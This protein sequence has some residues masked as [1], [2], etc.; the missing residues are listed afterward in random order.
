MNERTRA[1]PPPLDGEEAAIKRGVV[2][3]RVAVRRV[4]GIGRARV[5]HL[6][7]RSEAVARWLIA[8]AAAIRPAS[9]WTAWLAANLTL[10]HLP[11]GSSGQWAHAHIGPPP[12]PPA[13]ARGTCMAIAEGTKPTEP[14]SEKSAVSSSKLPN[15]PS[16]STTKKVHTS[17]AS[18][19]SSAKSTVSP[20]ARRA[21]MVT[22]A[23]ETMHRRSALRGESGSS[24]C[25]PTAAATASASSSAA[26]TAAGSE[27]L[28]SDAALAL[29]VSARAPSTAASSSGS[30]SATVALRS[31]PF[32]SVPSAAVRSAR[33]DESVKGASKAERIEP[34]SWSPCAHPLSA[35]PSTRHEA[36]CEVLRSSCIAW[37]AARSARG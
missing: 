28:P 30:A 19:A 6:E 32:P 21:S 5:A 10:A 15:S 35:A 8:T 20:A 29:P 26:C 4:G 7:G 14:R 27:E 24:A 3:L 2:E 23:S 34:T 16:H 12:P 11:E 1:P 33:S 22:V 13:C 9:A 17:F 18:S 25:A 36:P 31:D 37:R